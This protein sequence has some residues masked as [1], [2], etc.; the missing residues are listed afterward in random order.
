MVFVG[1]GQGHNQASRNLVRKTVHV[2]DLGGQQQLADVGENR[3]R[4]E[5]AAVRIL[6]A[7]HAG[8]HTT[9]IEAFGYLDELHHG[10]T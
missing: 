9:R 8:R 6:R 1:A 7:I 5:G 3:L 2:I 4:H 10:L